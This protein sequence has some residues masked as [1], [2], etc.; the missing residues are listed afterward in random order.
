MFFPSEIVLDIT[1]YCDTV[2][3]ARCTFVCKQWR[4]CVTWSKPEYE[5]QLEQAVWLNYIDIVQNLLKEP[6]VDPTARNQAIIMASAHGHVD[7]VRLLLK[8]P[9]VDPAALRN[10]AISRASSSARVEVVRVLLDDPRVNPADAGNRAI[11]WACGSDFPPVLWF[12]WPDRNRRL[13]PRYAAIV[14][15]LLG[16]PR[17]DPTAANNEAIHVAN[18]CGRLAIVELLLKDPRMDPAV[19]KELLEH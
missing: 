14:E 16:D 6:N 15:M 7:L 19:A 17:V 2:T 3:K 8:D 9:R 10:L 4:Q 12:R 18:A 5:R 13:N 1:Q 11:Q